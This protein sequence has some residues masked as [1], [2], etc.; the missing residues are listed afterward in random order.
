MRPVSNVLLPICGLLI[1][2][3]SFSSGA[4]LAKGLFPALGALG[5]A[6]I[7]LVF[8]AI[9]M[10]V[11][12][13]AWRARITR[14]NWAALAIYG[15]TLCGM[16]LCFYLALTTLPLGVTSAIEFLGP[17][18]VSVI[19]SNNRRDIIWAALAALGLLLLMPLTGAR[20]PRSCRYHVGPGFGSL[21]G[22]LYHLWAEGWVTSRN[23]NRCTRDGYCGGYS[24]S[25]R[26]L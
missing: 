24:G 20:W 7:R 21:L 2:M 25:V 23:A 18:S 14:H 26:C 17:L 15:V 5:T 4:A 19:F 3:V 8:A 6:T 13:R 10:I 9:I 22:T 11:V 1:A 16:N 12:L